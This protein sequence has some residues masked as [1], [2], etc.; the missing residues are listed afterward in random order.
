MKYIN[1]WQYTNVYLMKKKRINLYQKVYVLQSERQRRL[2]FFPARI[3]D[4]SVYD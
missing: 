4:L 2:E 3:I 1:L